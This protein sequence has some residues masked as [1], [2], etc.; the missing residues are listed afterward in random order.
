MEYRW[1]PKMFTKCG[2]HLWLIPKYQ[3]HMKA[4][5]SF[6]NIQW[7]NECFISWAALII[8]LKS[9]AWERSVSI[10]VYHGV[11]CWPM[12]PLLVSS[13]RK[14]WEHMSPRMEIAPCTERSAE[15]RVI[16]VGIG[17]DEE[18]EEEQKKWKWGPLCK[19]SAQGHLFIQSPSFPSAPSLCLSQGGALK[20]VVF[21]GEQ[22]CMSNYRS[23]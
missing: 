8:I 9:E 3:Q 15:L 2:K 5:E 17:C 13:Q 14:K 18:K 12:C 1:N 16:V 10:P 7:C 11:H 21:W 6:I 20:E 19:K 23:A 4:R 22:W